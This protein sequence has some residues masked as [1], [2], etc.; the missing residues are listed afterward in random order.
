MKRIELYWPVLLKDILSTWRFPDFG[1]R[2][3]LEARRFM[4][5]IPCSLCT[6]SG[7]FH[8]H[9][10]SARTAADSATYETWFAESRAALRQSQW[11]CIESAGER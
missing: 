1:F 11:G 6:I 4:H 3:P 7:W 5:H 8:R 9:Q 10:R 2:T